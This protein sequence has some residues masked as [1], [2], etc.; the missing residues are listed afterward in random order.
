MGFFCGNLSIPSASDACVKESGVPIK[1][2][3][4][5]VETASG[6]VS[7]AT[8]P[9][10]KGLERRRASLGDHLAGES[11][12][13]AGDQV[14]A[15][16]RAARCSTTRGCSKK[17]RGQLLEMTRRRVHRVLNA[18]AVERVVCAPEARRVETTGLLGR[19]LAAA[20]SRPRACSVET[21]GLLGRDHGPARSRPRGCSVETTGPLGRDHAAARSRPR[22]CSVET[23]RLLGRD[24]GPARSRPPLGSSTG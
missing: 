7:I 16:R 4:E 21:T 23:S 11:H 3:D 9:L 2:L 18:R 5:H 12:E 19:D 10:A 17:T 1:V 20:R 14:E 6:H 8:V 15:G 13:S 22:A 24:H